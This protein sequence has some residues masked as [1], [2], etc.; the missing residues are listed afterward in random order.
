ML[1]ISWGINSQLGLTVLGLTIG[2]Q[3][4]L[5]LI[6]SLKEPCALMVIA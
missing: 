5:L 3:L 1:A 2:H 4:F 6:N